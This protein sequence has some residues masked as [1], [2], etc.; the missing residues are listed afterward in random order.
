MLKLFLKGKA[1]QLSILPVLLFFLLSRDLNMFAQ[2]S[3][4]LFAQTA[5]EYSKYCLI[6]SFLYCVFCVWGVAEGESKYIS[7]GVILAL[8]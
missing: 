4:H 1:V 6:F 2:I 8:Y 7:F 3:G 5:V